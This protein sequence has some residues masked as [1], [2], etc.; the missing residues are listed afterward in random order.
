MKGV[1]TLRSGIMLLE[2]PMGVVLRSLTSLEL[3]SV[4]MFFISAMWQWLKESPVGEEIEN[5]GKAIATETLKWCF[6]FDGFTIILMETE[7]SLGKL[8]S[9]WSSETCAGKVL[10]LRPRKRTPFP[11]REMRGWWRSARTRL[12]DRRPP[13]ARVR[14]AARPRGPCGPQVAARPW[15]ACRRSARPALPCPALPCPAR[16]AARGWTLAPG[17]WHPREY[18]CNDVVACYSCTTGNALGLPPSCLEKVGRSAGRSR[19]AGTRP[20][21]SWCRGSPYPAWRGRSGR[22][23]PAVAREQWPA[24]QHLLHLSDWQDVQAGDIL[25]RPP[26]PSIRGFPK[27]G[28]S[29]LNNADL[30]A[31][32]DFSL[33]G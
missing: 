21:P 16:P 6:T 22:R 7:S 13:A 26:P 9:K 17:R 20:A 29:V 11:P 33:P 19:A 2:V 31:R 14:S 18:E 12:P 8:R 1:C 5:E 27:Q 3:C 23:G 15:P 25:P 4:E 30:R 32:V 10:P 28:H 24:G